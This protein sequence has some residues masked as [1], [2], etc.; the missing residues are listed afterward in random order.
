MLKKTKCLNC[1]GRGE[2]A[3][4]A[5]YIEWWGD[6]SRKNICPECNGTGEITTEIIEW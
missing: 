6:G 1:D 2:F 3:S 4:F 5:Y